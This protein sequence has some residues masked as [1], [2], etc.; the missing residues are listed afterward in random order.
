MRLAVTRAVRRW[1]AVAVLAAAG[2]CALW[3]VADHRRPGPLQTETVLVI[4][5]GTS[6]WAMGR[7]LAEAGAIYRPFSFVAAAWFERSARR[8][9][10]GEYAFGPA[11]TEAEIL[12]MIV[13]GRTVVR[14]LTVPEGLTAARVMALVAAADGLAGDLPPLPEEGSLLPETY[15]YSLGD[16]RT[17]MIA[18]MS[19]G[20]RDTAQA[21]WIARAPELPLAT[22]RDAVILASIIEK[23][24]GLADERAKVA[25]VFVNR[26]RRDLPLESDPTV[27]YALTHGARE[28]DRELRKADLALRDPYNTYV[29][30]GLPPGPIANPGRAALEA[31]LNPAPMDALYFVADGA[32]GHMFSETLKDHRRA[33]AKWRAR[34]K[35][36]SDSV[37]ATRPKASAKKLGGPAG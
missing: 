25:A 5:P 21:L 31:A 3:F 32:G 36:A 20:M 35:P 37:A 28:L 27:A 9:R 19:K 7:R 8:L 16:T 24:T 6:A 4:P 33:V 30:R 26:L 23:E 29:R 11:M 1:L 12:A 10:A 22:P 18:R 17:A 2:A 34:D 15:Y 14:R 13:D